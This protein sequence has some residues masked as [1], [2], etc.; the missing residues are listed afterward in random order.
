MK[1]K[2]AYSLTSKE[3]KALRREE[4]EKKNKT[5]KREGE[6]DTSVVSEEITPNDGQAVAQTLSKKQLWIPVT[7]IVLA[8]IIILTAVLLLVFV[9]RSQSRYPRA[10]IELNDGRKLT[11]TIWE[12]DCPIAATNFIFLGKIGFFTFDKGDSKGSLIYDVQENNRYMRFGA[13][14]DYASDAT[15]YRQAE[16]VNSI[17]TDIFNVVNVDP[18][19][20]NNVQSNKFGYRLYR[21][22]GTTKDRYNEKYVLSFH[23]TNVGDF[24]INMGDNNRNFG[25]LNSNLTAF[26]QFEDKASQDVLDDIFAMEKNENTGISGAIG[27]QTP[28]RIRKISF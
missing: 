22:S 17:P 13:Y 18:S 10:V 2:P 23:T 11:L 3:R 5:A 25:D 14:Y 24:V 28:V 7:G 4:E 6:E 8:L 19:Y 12:E 27:T 1:K 26:G 15:R 16:F 9:P 21:D 20:E